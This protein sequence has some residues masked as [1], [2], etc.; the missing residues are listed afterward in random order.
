[1]KTF[2]LNLK[3]NFL[4]KSAKTRP[5]RATFTQR[6]TWRQKNHVA[7]TYSTLYSE[8]AFEAK[9]LRPTCHT[10]FWSGRQ[11]F[12]RKKSSGLWCFHY[13]CT[14]TRFFTLAN[15]CILSICDDN[16]K[17]KFGNNGTRSAKTLFEIVA[18]DVKY[19]FI[20]YESATYVQ[21]YGL[22]TGS[23]FASMFRAICLARVYRKIGNGL[24][25]TFFGF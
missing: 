16:D 10:E 11:A 9:D 25:K 13:T 7:T 19:I 4:A 5:F 3:C 12:Q 21:N 24:L 22:C 23:T 2:I 18:S 17:D 1:M 14:S 6:T 8:S 15:S 20:R